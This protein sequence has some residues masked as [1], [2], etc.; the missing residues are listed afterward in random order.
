MRLASAERSAS[1]SEEARRRHRDAWLLVLALGCA[2]IF[3]GNLLGIGPWWLASAIAAC[4]IVYGVV[5]ARHVD[6]VDVPGDTKGDSIYYLGLLFTFA[7]L[8]AELISFDWG[9]PGGDGSGTAG[10]I[11]NFGIALLTT[12]VG[13]AGRVWFTMS[14]ESPGTS[15]TPP[16][17]GW[18]RR[19]R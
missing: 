13:L 12:I 16:G 6:D 1:Q 3:A 9:T 14:Q 4:M 2:I 17:P 11:R 15:W 10:S 19:W 5:V 18:R 7:A 8:V